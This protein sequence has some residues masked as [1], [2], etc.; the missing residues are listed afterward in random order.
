LKRPTIKG[1]AGALLAVAVV[2]A[3]T[4]APN[5]LGELAPLP[6][7]E[8]FISKACGGAS[9]CTAPDRARWVPHLEKLLRERMPGL[10]EQDRS[11]LA[12]VIYEEAKA[13]SLDP[14]FVLAVIAVESG[15]DNDAES[16][17]GAK[18][19]MQLTPS[20]LKR[21]T[22]RWRFM[23]SDLD[24]PVVN[25][26]AGVR[27]LRRLVHMFGST[28]VALM[29][30]NAGPNR[31]LKYL[32]DEGDIPDRFLVY[33]KKVNGE[34]TRLRKRSPSAANGNAIATMGAD[35][36]RAERPDGPAAEAGALEPR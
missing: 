36:A 31:I 25:V 4:I 30:Y 16:P 18:G 22:Q 20:T 11:R 9:P 12:S 6:R 17:A 26:R 10:P 2:A 1:C 24:D 3:G 14:F 8:T 27:Y 7:I 29:A 23:P 35:P 34:L 33:P 13:A 28:D 32:E 15:F 19:L 5:T 21:E